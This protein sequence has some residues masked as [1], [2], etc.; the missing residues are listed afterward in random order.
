MTGLY[1]GCKF[2]QYSPL[3]SEKFIRLLEVY[4]GRV[5]DNIDCT[6]HQTELENAPK[7]EAISYA[8]GDPTNKV[9]VLC[10]GKII[11]V[12]QNLRDALLRLKLKDRS[13]IIWADAICISQDDDGEK[14]SQVKLMGRIYGNA[15]RV[16]VWLGCTTAQ[17]QPAFELI[18]KMVSHSSPTS[19][20]TSSH[21]DELSL[22]LTF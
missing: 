1:G 5:S 12:T 20:R 11:T 9:N 8:W 13:K 16:C 3:P 4:P 2:Y 17:M 22:F 19:N 18:D 10:D 21:L 15:T 6:L 7:Y 14:G